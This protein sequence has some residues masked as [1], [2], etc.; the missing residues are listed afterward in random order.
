M[1]TRLGTAGR[2]TGSPPLKTR[3]MPLPPVHELFFS[4]DGLRLLWPLYAFLPEVTGVCGPS[5]QGAQ[6][7]HCSSY[8]VKTEIGDH[9]F[10]RAIETKTQKVKKKKK[11]ESELSKNSFRSN[12]SWN[13]TAQR[14]AAMLM[15]PS[16]N[17]FFFFLKRHRMNGVEKSKGYNIQRLTCS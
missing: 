15:F 7:V 9:P 1:T 6:T 13:L 4:E 3:L 2:D 5:F 17:S 14:F 16:T 12:I 11:K 8:S 10:F